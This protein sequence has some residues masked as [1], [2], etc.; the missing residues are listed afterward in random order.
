MKTFEE[1]KKAVIAQAFDL[2]DYFYNLKIKKDDIE[3]P[4]Y[5]PKYSDDSLNDI[6]MLSDVSFKQYVLHHTNTEEALNNLK[7]YCNLLHVFELLYDTPEY[8][9][10]I[11]IILVLIKNTYPVLG[12]D[13]VLIELSNYFYNYYHGSK[14]ELNPLRLFAFA[15]RLSNHLVESNT[16]IQREIKTWKAHEARSIESR[17]YWNKIK[18]IFQ[19][20]AEALETNP[21]AQFGVYFY[22]KQADR[23]EG[24][25]RETGE[26]S[27]AKID[28]ETNCLEPESKMYERNYKQWKTNFDR[29]N[30]RRH[31]GDEEQ[32]LVDNFEKTLWNYV[33]SKDIIKSLQ[34][35]LNI[36]EEMKNTE[37]MEK[38]KL[39]LSD[40][41]QKSRNIKKED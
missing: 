3:I 30:K 7:A 26:W 4:D 18:P 33:D 10:Q 36:Q 2:N 29:W 14:E 12:N 25:L 35:H 38:S 21:N 39:F 32:Q 15:V 28:K 37:I 17:P 9:E 34:N 40:F 23:L 41:L 5:L 24:I 19:A 1:E 31:N 20:Y 6:F 8:H 13:L 16:A 22:G 27:E 11:Y